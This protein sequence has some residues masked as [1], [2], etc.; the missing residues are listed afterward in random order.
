MTNLMGTPIPGSAAQ[1]A[2]ANAEIFPETV[3]GFSESSRV[4]G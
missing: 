3:M 4:R 1:K 2:S